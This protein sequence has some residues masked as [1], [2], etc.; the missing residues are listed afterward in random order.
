M[1]RKSPGLIQISLMPTKMLIHE[2]KEP[3]VF[4]VYDYRTDI[5]GGDVMP[6]RHGLPRR[7][8]KI[9]HVTGIVEDSVPGAAIYFPGE[10]RLAL[11]ISPANER[12]RRFL[13]M[14][15][16]MNAF[17]TAD[18]SFSLFQSNSS[19]DGFLSSSQ[20]TIFF[21][22][23]LWLLS[24]DITW[25]IQVYEPIQNTY[26]LEIKIHCLPFKMPLHF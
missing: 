13:R 6:A 16:S 19:T 2:T 15:Y 4:L 17:H 5:L 12:A 25:L 22:K 3:A 10:L 26:V 9:R 20:H 14:C 7:F 11:I 1:Y 21:T 24:Q 18:H 8:W 23:A